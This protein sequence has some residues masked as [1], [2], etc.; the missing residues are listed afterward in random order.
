MGTLPFQT[1]PVAITPDRYLVGQ[2]DAAWPS[3]VMSA[4][5]EV[6][7]VPPG[8]WVV[9]DETDTPGTGEPL[10]ARLPAA[11]GDVTEAKLWGLVAMDDTKP[12]EADGTV[13]YNDGDLAPI[14]VR[15]RMAVLPED[16]IAIGAA[17]FVRHTATPP[18]QLGAMRSDADTADAVILTQA[19]TVTAM[20][21]ALIG[22]IEVY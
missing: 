10:R 13:V 7:G 9:L 14:M 15:G 20:G 12:Q 18:E 3:N 1:D 2:I 8:V 5:I 6:D 16:T 4:R 17:P 21:A 11:A 22:V 19:R